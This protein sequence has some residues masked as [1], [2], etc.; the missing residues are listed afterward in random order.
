MKQLSNREI[1]ELNEK[2][3]ASFGILEFFGKKDRVTS[4]DNLIYKNSEPQFFLKENTIYPTLY[5]LQKNNFL[6][7]ATIDLPAVRFIVG[8]ADVMRPGIVACDDFMERDIVAVVD[9]KNKKPIAVGIALISSEELLNLDKGKAVKT[10]HYVGDTIWNAAKE[11][12][13]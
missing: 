2:I 11:S 1:K 5:L 9:E 13:D 10:I 6:K 8:G 12:Q 3:S 7:T 4:T